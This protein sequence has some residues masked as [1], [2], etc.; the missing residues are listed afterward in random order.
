ML[1]FGSFDKT[2]IVRNL[3]N[4]TGAD[5]LSSFVNGSM[6]CQFYEGASAGYTGNGI[7]NEY[8]VDYSNDADD[9]LPRTERT[10]R[11]STPPRRDVGEAVFPEI[12]MAFYENDRNATILEPNMTSTIDNV[13]QAGS[14][15]QVTMSKTNFFGSYPA[16]WAGLALRNISRGHWKSNAWKDILSASGSVALLNGTVDWLAGE[17]VTVVPRIRT[18]D[19]REIGHTDRYYYNVTVNGT[20]DWPVGQAVKDFSRGLWNYTDWGVIN[21]STRANNQTRVQ[22]LMDSSVQADPGWAVGDWIGYVRRFTEAD[23]PEWG[24]GL[25]RNHYVLYVESDA[26]FDTRPGDIDTRRTGVVC[27]GDAVIKGPNRI[28]MEKRPLLYP[29]LAT[30]NGNIYSDAPSGNANQRIGKRIFDD[31]IFTENGD[32]D[33]NYV[34]CQAMYGANVTLSGIFRMQYDPDLTRLGGYAFGV[35]GM[36][37]LEE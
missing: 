27:E 24:N 20:L 21:A 3:F 16:Q 25:L 35:S 4:W 36:T 8:G 34:D 22:I 19:F 29:N 2:M 14:N 28:R 37:W 1:D 15:T 17:R 23:A 11:R 7:Y 18:I 10:R 5:R 30:E 31:I 13:T 33:F 26:L 12:D 32:I 6:L 9:L